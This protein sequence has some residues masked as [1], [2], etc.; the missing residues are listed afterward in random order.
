M[1]GLISS[2]T[3]YFATSHPNGEEVVGCDASGL[4]ALGLSLDLFAT[5]TIVV[6]SIFALGYWLVAALLFLH[7][8]DNRLALFA[9][10]CLATFPIAFNSGF[11]SILAGPWWFLAH[12]ISFLGDLCIVLFFYVFPTGHFVPRWSRF[13]LVPTL[14]YWGFKEF[15]PGAP[16][17][18]FF[19]FPVLNSVLFLGVVGGMVVVQVYRYRRVSTPVQRQQTKW[20]VYGVSMG[21]GGFLVLDLL[22]LFFPALFPGGSL[23]SVIVTLA[24]SGLMLLPPVLAT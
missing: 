5:Y 17:N 4:Q 6:T 8:S 11:M 7:K 22:A 1:K 14:L 16:F 13:V 20:V 2:L 23:A 3:S 10:V 21:V 9:V 18:P 15:F 24:I 19:R 12:V